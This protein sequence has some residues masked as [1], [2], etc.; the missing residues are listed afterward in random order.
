MEHAAGMDMVAVTL[1][2]HS[3]GLW[4]AGDS[5]GCTPAGSVTQRVA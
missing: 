4:L 5:R 3:P 2:R 1:P